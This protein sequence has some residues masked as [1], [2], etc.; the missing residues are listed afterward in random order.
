M[1]RLT[2]ILSAALFGMFM[3]SSCC[4]C[5]KDHQCQCQCKGEGEASCQTE[6]TD[7]P[8]GEGK[9]P[10]EGMRQGMPPCPTQGGCPKMKAQMEKW[11]KFDSL[12][13]DEQKALLKERKEAIDK[14]QAEME[15]K[16]AEME[17]KWAN[18]DSLTIEEQKQLIDM[19]SGPMF[20]PHKGFPKGPRT[21]GMRGDKR[22]HK[23][24][25]PRPERN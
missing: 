5:D 19:K 9:C 2:T 4:N 3:M 7:K 16:K 21:E 22:G 8:F 10:R 23:H 15:A 24:H 1:K 25:G 18:F 12:S 11:M 6:C 20:G 13:V 17:Q 14:M